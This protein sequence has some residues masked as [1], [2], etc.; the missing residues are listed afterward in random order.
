MER[1]A[2]KEGFKDTGRVSPNLSYCK[3]NVI[4]VFDNYRK[5][6]QYGKDKNPNFY[7]NTL[8]YEQNE[9]YAFL[10]HKK[11]QLSPGEKVNGTDIRIKNWKD[12]KEDTFKNLIQ[13]LH[14]K[15]FLTL[16]DNHLIYKNDEALFHSLNNFYNND[17]LT[18]FKSLAGI[19]RTFNVALHDEGDLIKGKL[20]IEYI[21]DGNYLKTYHDVYHR[22]DNHNDGIIYSY[23][24]T[25]TF[26]RD[27]NHLV[28]QDIPTKDSTDSGQNYRF[29]RF[30]VTKFDAEGRIFEGATWLDSGITNITRRMFIDNYLNE[31]PYPDKDIIAMSRY[32]NDLPCRYKQKLIDETIYNNF[33]LSGIL[34]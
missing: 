5:M 18:D 16:Y 6:V 7:I 32:K 17:P 14:D 21:E 28:M 22:H 13:L 23:S 24:G 27:K 1:I 19:Y 11:R 26:Y 34:G 30:H 8:S 29:H 20:V 15:G 31:A 2:V 33:N 4:H 3:E 10:R 12:I 9:K 25:I